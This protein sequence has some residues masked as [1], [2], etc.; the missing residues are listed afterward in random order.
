MELVQQNKDFVCFCNH[1]KCVKKKNGETHSRYALSEFSKAY[2]DMC[3][4]YISTNSTY[5]EDDNF[6]RFVALN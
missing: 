6:N 4:L 1:K 5:I 2:S 3:T